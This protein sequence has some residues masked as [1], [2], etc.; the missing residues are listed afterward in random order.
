M[1]Q[2]PGEVLLEEGQPPAGR[3][4][5]CPARGGAAQADREAAL[6]DLGEVDVVAADG[7]QD[8]VGVPAQRVGLGG[9]G[10]GAVGGDEDQ[11]GVRVD[12]DP[13]VR[14]QAHGL[15]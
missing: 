6:D 4:D 3:L 15:L 12:G 1:V 11:A 5:Q 2:D 7:E 14:T 13:P 10:T 8:Q 9:E